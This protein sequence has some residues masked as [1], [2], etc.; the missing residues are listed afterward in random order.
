MAAMD[1][2]E[3]RIDQLQDALQAV[4]QPDREAIWKGILLTPTVK[5]QPFYRQQWKWMVVTGLLILGSSYL[6][7]WY[8]ETKKSPQ[9]EI[10]LADLPLEY[11]IKVRQYQTLVGQKEAIL[12]INRPAGSVAAEELQELQLLDSI[13]Q[14]FLADFK[15]LPKNERTIQRCLIYYEQKIRILELALKE[16]QIHKHEKE[17]NTSLQI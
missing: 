1:P 17:R 13:Q 16:I 3:K 12:H 2:L 14:V 10:D 4:E 8:S 15:A 6:G 7:Y 9:K 11:Q 5:N